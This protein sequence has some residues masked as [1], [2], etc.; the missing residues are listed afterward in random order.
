MCDER[1]RRSRRAAAQ[2]QVDQ[3]ALLEVEQQEEEE[4]GGA[5]GEQQQQQQQQ[6]QHQRNVRR[7][8]AGDDC[9]EQ[10]G[11]RLSG[12]SAPPPFRPRRLTSAARRFWRRLG[13]LATCG[14]RPSAAAW[15]A[16]GACCVR[17]RTALCDVV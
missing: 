8:S 5:G 17:T 15:R 2:Q 14:F 13:G 6:Q 16:A 4:H 3:S 7:T 9:E 12:C 11:S 10:P 1:R